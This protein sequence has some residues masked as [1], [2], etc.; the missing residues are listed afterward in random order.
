MHTASHVSSR[1]INTR[2]EF[3]NKPNEPL[4]HYYSD[5]SL[6]DLW[7]LVSIT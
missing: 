2:R 5:G 7:K 1:K 6:R 4:T 3:A